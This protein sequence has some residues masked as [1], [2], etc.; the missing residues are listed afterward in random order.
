[1]TTL[2]GDQ[3]ATGSIVA[4]RYRVLGEAGKGGMA[5]V[6]RAE[7]LRGRGVV[8]VK[9]MLPA[10]AS[11]PTT[12]LLFDDEVRTLGDL[13]HPAI[14]GLRDAGEDKLGPYV[15]LEW[16]EGA[17][18]RELIAHAG[19]LP[20]RA[21]VALGLELL[22]V[23][24]DLH[25]GRAGAAGRRWP[26]I[27][28]D[29]SP[30]NVMV[31]ERGTVKLVDFGLARALGRA[32][33][34]PPGTAAGKPGYLPP[35][36]LTG[37]LHGTRADVYSAGAVLWE[38]LAGRGLFRGIDD[39]RELARAMLRAP[40]PALRTVRKDVP[41]AIAN[42]IDGALVLDPAARFGNA[43]VMAEALRAA[44]EVHGMLGRR[45]DMSAL[46]KSLQASRKRGASMGRGR[47][48]RPVGLDRGAGAQEFAA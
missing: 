5:A 6:L 42:V 35:E 23:L 7:D 40:R 22:A 41:E 15:A 13:A 47:R 32:R 29:I 26:V 36:V 28:R 19:A 30:T 2:A 46:V 9:R 3:H 25:A 11:D 37:G 14:V 48:H 8:A 17:S 16:I 39:E 18:V 1:M 34:L 43:E 45:A 24:S 21:V 20:M 38:S 12:R 33:T 44:A 31:T 10:M 27:H 4:G